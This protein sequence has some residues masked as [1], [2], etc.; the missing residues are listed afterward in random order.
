MTAQQIQLQCGEVGLVDSRLGEVSESRID[1]VDGGVAFGLRI[2]DG[3]CGRHARPRIRRES[4]LGAIV[5]D[6]EQVLER[7]IGSVE[8]NHRVE[9]PL[10]TY[11]ETQ[12]HRSTYR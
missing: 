1:A 7:E 12:T 5:G 8:E 3:A 11:T 9:G 6:R 10:T 4:D 2:N